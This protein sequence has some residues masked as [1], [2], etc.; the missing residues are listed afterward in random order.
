MTTGTSQ[1]LRD[2]R[3]KPKRIKDIEVKKKEKKKKKD[4]EV[5]KNAM[6]S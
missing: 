1:R 2:S 5:W 6:E 3:N 4:I